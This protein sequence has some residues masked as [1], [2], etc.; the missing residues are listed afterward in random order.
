[1]YHSCQRALDIGLPS[2]AFTEHVDLAAWYIEDERTRRDP[3]I[4]PGLDATHHFHPPTFD[5]DGYA[6]AID[7]CRHAF[8]DLRIVTGLEI[9]EPHWFAEHTAQLLASGEFTRVLGSQHSL[10]IGN[11]LRLVDEWYVGIADEKGDAAAIRSYLAATIELVEQS[12]AFEVVAHI[13]Y[14]TRQIDRSGR[15]HDPREFEDEYRE[16]LRAVRDADR[17]LEINTRRPLDAVIV[18]W[19]HEVGGAAVS[20]GSDAHQP[21]AVAADFAEA[22]DLAEAAGFCPQ[23]DPADFW[24]R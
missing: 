20:F 21:D 18:G 23:Q 10:Q 12:D 14:L 13:D 7:R 22:A 9:G 17:I 11:D 16:T 3:L 15:R 5:A 4:A 6:D 24:R 2:I 1:M 19:W 8:P